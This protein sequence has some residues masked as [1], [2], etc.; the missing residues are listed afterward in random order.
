MYMYNIQIVTKMRNYGIAEYR[1]DKMA[2]SAYVH[3]S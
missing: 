3:G 1:K 2:Q